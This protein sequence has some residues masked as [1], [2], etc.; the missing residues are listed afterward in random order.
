MIKK[1]L[2]TTTALIL[3]ASVSGVAARPEA[4]AGSRMRNIVASRDANEE[5]LCNY[6]HFNV[7]YVFTSSS[8]TTLSTW[9][10]V[11][12]PITG[13]GQTVHGIIV[14]EQLGRFSSYSSPEFSV[15]IYSN[16]PSGFPG[17]LIAGG[18]GK[19]PYKCAR[20]EVSIPRTKLKRKTTYWI[21]ETVPQPFSA[22]NSAYWAIDPKTKHRAYVQSHYYH[23][24]HSSSST[25]AWRLQTAGPYFRLKEVTGH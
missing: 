19:L 3:V 16:S 11:A 2:L 18:S 22:T 10:H 17:K 13:H 12:A 9:T 6:G 20:T 25:T 14:E 7:S 8:G 1:G 24:S 23:S 4:T 21:E 5:F 15:G